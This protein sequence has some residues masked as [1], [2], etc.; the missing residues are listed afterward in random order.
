MTTNRPIKNTAFRYD[1][2][3]LRAFAVLV[4]VFFHFQVPYFSA[5]F[6]GVD[7]FF[8]ISGFLMTG[9]VC[10]ALANER[11]SFLEFYVAR[12]RR[13]WPALIVLS[14]VVLVLGWF[15]LMSADYKTL[16]AHVRESLLFTSNLKYL[17]EAG[18]FDQASHSKWL[19]HTW[20]LSVEWQFYLFYP[21]CVVLFFKLFGKSFALRYLLAFHLLLVAAF[22]VVNLYYI[23]ISVE[24]AFYSLEA[25]A[26]EMLLGGL[27]Y[28]VRS[29]LP[30]PLRKFLLC[31]GLSLLVISLL[32]IEPSQAW[33][34]QYA[35]L[36]TIGA[37][38]IILAAHNSFFARFGFMQWVG[39][40][41]YSIYLWHWPLVVL[42]NYYALDS[43][44]YSVLFI[45]LSLVLG[46][47]S[48][49]LVE[50]PTRNKL[51]R[52]SARN[53]LVY[54]VAFLLCAVALALI[55]RR[56][57]LPW[58]L[59][60]NIVAIE[61]MTK[62]KNPRQTECLS[63]SASCVFGGDKIAAVVL[64]D[65]HA[66]SIVTGV[67]AALADAKQG[68]VLRAA[69][70]CLVAKGAQ[71]VKERSKSCESMV[72]NIES[73]IAQ[74]YPGVP[75]LVTNRWPFYLYGEP[76]KMERTG[77]AD[78]KVSFSAS[79]DS[80]ETAFEQGV[81]DRL[82]AISKTNSVYVLRTVPE[83]PF[84][85]PREMAKIALR[86]QEF[87]EVKMP[88]KLYQQRNSFVD[89]VLAKAEEK[90]GVRVL[91][92]EP[93]LCDDEFCYGAREDK[94]LY[95]DDDHLSETGNRVLL[96]LFKQIYTDEVWE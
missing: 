87:S 44:F 46:H 51:S 68:V 19:L 81:L 77:I 40:R 91:N 48:Y 88:R 85:V 31:L 11:F 84:N 75:V 16:A 86:G 10:K 53:N 58:R 57:G 8:V 78:P 59:P 23:S 33:P 5:G 24:K 79:S 63:A 50:T 66:D 70:G 96:E 2:N 9:I 22:F 1:I 89:T 62:D 71:L 35:L 21:V 94:A 52:L 92:P 43:T 20:S 26:W 69:S 6:I 60:E 28:F 83:M 12:A 67:A 38:A 30:N 73:E 32:I 55:V 4:V 72:D 37:L 76:S 49:W 41:S 45:A 36:P 3:A 95:V 29:D 74:L 14:L 42:I 13:I 25:R 54:L 34:G 90:C 39:E 61:A 56:D 82:C 7:V 65:S 27:A 18:Y 17:S 93:Y 64:G 47:L 15:I 80:L